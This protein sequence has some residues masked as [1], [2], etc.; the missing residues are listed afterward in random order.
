MITYTLSWEF[1]KKSAKALPHKLWKNKEE[2]ANISLDFGLIS[3]YAQ[4]YKPLAKGKSRD[5]LD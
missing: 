4:R 2:S 5:K 1:F 3:R